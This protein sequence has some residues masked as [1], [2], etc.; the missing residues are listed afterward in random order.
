[1]NKDDILKAFAELSP[2]DQK[3]V[4]TE[5][6]REEEV[7]E[8]GSPFGSGGMKEHMKEMMEKMKEGGDPMAICKEMMKKCC[9]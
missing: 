8:A 5:L 2:E 4:R 6:T 7:E 1:M 9:P 3:A